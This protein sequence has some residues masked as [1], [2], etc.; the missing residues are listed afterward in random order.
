M[1]LTARRNLYPPPP[2]PPSVWWNDV[3]I[4]RPGPLGPD[5]LQPGI[6]A[7]G[8]KQLSAQTTDPAAPAGRFG[9]TSGVLADQLYVYGGTAATGAVD[10]LW[11]FN[12]PAARW[13][14]VSFSGPSPGPLIYAAAGMFLGDRFFVL[15][16]GGAN[17]ST[18]LHTFTPV[19]GCATAA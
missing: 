1:R 10:D 11:A 8:W 3:W 2:G 7:A 6:G 14:A 12:I 5:G 13:S 15:G 9:H 19:M 17:S 16:R 4:F 18:E